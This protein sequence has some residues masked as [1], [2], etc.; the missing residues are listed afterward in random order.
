MKQR[1]LVTLLGLHLLASSASYATCN[2][3]IIKNKPDSLYTDNA[4]GTVTDTKTKLMWQ[5]CSVGQTYTA[6][7]C[8]GT[9]TRADW[10]AALTAANTNTQYGYSDWRVPNKNELSS[11]VEAACYLPSINTMLFPAIGT[12]SYWSASP[13]ANKSLYAWLVNFNDGDVHYN[14]KGN[15]YHVRLVRGG[16]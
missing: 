2:T 6:G 9:A 14:W 16:Y 15:N 4:N 10:K 3:N 7:T 5:K 1:L 13:Y 8:T 12:G 11:L